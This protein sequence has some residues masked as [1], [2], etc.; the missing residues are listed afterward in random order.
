[1]KPNEKGKL[2]QSISRLLL[3]LSAMVLLL[4]LIGAFLYSQVNLLLNQYMQVQGEKQAETLAELTERQFQVELT[5]LYTVANELPEIKG[6]RAAALRALQNADYEGHIGVLHVDGRAFFGENYSVDDFPCLEDALH[7]ENSISFCP[8]K[9]LMFCVPAMRDKNIAFVVYRLYSEDIL[10]SRFGVISYSGSGSTRIKGSNGEIVVTSLENAP[11]NPV[12]DEPQVVSATQELE[13]M[14]YSQKSAASFVKTSLGETM[15]YVANISDSTYHLVGY[16]PKSV[17]MEGVQG[18]SVLVIMVFSGLALALLLGGILL[19]GFEKKSRESDALREAA[20]VAEK[21]SAAKSLFLSNMS[22]DIRTPMN[23]II[24]YTNLA[25]QNPEDTSLVQDYLG[26]ILSSAGHLLSLINDVLEMSRIE[27]GKIQLEEDP[28]SLPEIL[29]DLNTLIFSQVEEKGQSLAMN[30]INVEHEVVCCDKLRLSQILLNLLSNAIKFTPE[31]GKISLTLQEEPAKEEGTAFYELR[32]KDNGIGMSETFAANVFVPFEREYTSTVSKIQGTGL[33]MA[34]TKNIVELMG[35]D[36]Q[37][38]TKLGEGTEF[39]LHLPFRLPEKEKK[40]EEITLPALRALVVDDEEAMCES[41]CRLLQKL[42]L[43]CSYVLSGEEALS[44][45]KKAKETEEPFG[46]YLIDWKMPEMDG[47][48]AARELRSILGNE[49]PILLFTGYDS[50][51][52]REEAL[53]AGISGFCQKPLFTSEV[54]QILEELLLEHKK[55]EE[56]EEVPAEERFAGK[57]IL[58]VDDIE[59]NRE[60]AEDLL[61]LS[62]FEVDEASDGD[63]AV[64]MV[65]KAEAGAYDAILMDL[66]MPRLGGCDATRQ[67]RASGSPL[68]NI[69]IIAVTANAFE[70]DRKAAFAAGMNA[71]TPKPID[72]DVLL[73]I[74]EELLA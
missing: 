44:L 17:V 36:I 45:A 70:E 29:H 18:I 26:K 27:S 16:V 40:E 24:G 74:L 53:A 66:Q 50:T 60:I 20:R 7:G 15:L 39:I 14:L 47:L 64:E 49:V 35:G 31:G 21:A 57:R 3:S 72:L 55:Q 67:I 8:G 34:I 51:S 23:A 58:V 59:I 11:T 65:T 5:S 56:K 2:D 37:V 12:F 71:F 42:G 1:M 13:K 46:L 54:R 4:V 52:I 69:P 73:G 28:A 6:M 61:T 63:I 62:G 32:V 19:I 9:G 68:A 30:A 48:C 25:I 10:Y 43:T 22:H 33:G 41:A 38:K